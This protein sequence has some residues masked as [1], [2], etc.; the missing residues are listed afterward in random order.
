MAPAIN[1]KYALAMAVMGGVNALVQSTNARRLGSQQMSRQRQ[2][3][4]DANKIQ[5]P[6]IAPELLEGRKMREIALAKGLPGLDQYKQSIEAS[7]ANLAAKGKEAAGSGGDYLALLSSLYASGNK[8]LE[9]LNTA[10]ANSRASQFDSLASYKQMLSQ[11]EVQNE[12]IK[13]QQQDELFKQANDLETAAT[14]NKLLADKQLTGAFT[15]TA[16]GIMGAMAAKNASSGQYRSSFDSQAPEV[17]TETPT[18]ISGGIGTT[19]PPSDFT[20]MDGALLDARQNAGTVNILKN[21]NITPTG[22]LDQI[23][24]AQAHLKGAGFYD[25]SIDGLYG[26]KTKKAM[27]LYLDRVG[28]NYTPDELSYYYSQSLRPK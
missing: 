17:G 16:S 25:G 22:S 20:D 2:L 27:E 7:T 4:A 13:R 3:R 14:E 28:D 12:A 1:A 24:S 19:A 10:D 23:K 8:S 18:S 26:P 11:Q 5:A 9:R 15:N 6:A 21:L